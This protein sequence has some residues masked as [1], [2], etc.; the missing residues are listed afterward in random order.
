[1]YIR[2][3]D[4]TLRFP[5]QGSL[6]PPPEPETAGAT[7]AGPLPGT[8]VPRL[9]GLR[10]I[11][12][13]R[14]VVTAL[15]RVT[16]AVEQGDRLGIVGHNGS[17]KSTLLRLLSGIYHPQAGRIERRGSISGIFNMSIGFRQEA[18]GYRNIRMKGL[19][20]GLTRRQIEAM[21]REIEQFTG[22]GAYLAM[23]LHTYSQGMALRLAFAITTAIRHDILLMDEWIGA[24]DA[25]FQEKV[26]ARMDDL[27]EKSRICIVASHNIQL[28]Q[29]VSD[30][31]LWLESGR[32]R[33]I[34]PTNE[35]LEAYQAD[36]RAQSIPLEGG[37]QR[38]PIEPGTSV[39][40]L[41]RTNGD[42]AWELHWDVAAYGVKRVRIMLV[43]PARGDER[44][45]VT[46]PPAGQR[47]PG[48]WLKSG[49]AF[50]LL[51]DTDGELLDSVVVD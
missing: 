21:T 7:N 43:D 2:A 39:L 1:M 16:L 14:P 49:I 38:R 6:A 26:V 17:G 12:R 11:F 18:S 3:H 8:D 34:G 48:D 5:F 51:D 20:A 10:G 9:G 36:A 19:M 15:D 31:C 35:I 41:R 40:E 46:G 23:P 29:R 4:V 30:R 33:D 13:G 44:L 24:G 50:R 22:L 37:M 42:G 27:L 32:V 47:R 25:E 45:F 28:L